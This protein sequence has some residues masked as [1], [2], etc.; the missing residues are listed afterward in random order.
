MLDFQVFALT[1]RHRSWYLLTASRKARQPSCPRP[2]GNRHEHI[3][4]DVASKEV[5]SGSPQRQQGTFFWQPAAP[6]RK[7]FLA[8]RS[9]SKGVLR[10]PRLR[11]DTPRPPGSASPSAPRPQGRRSDPGSGSPG[12]IRQ[13]E[14]C[15]EQV[16]L[17]VVANQQ[18]L[19]HRSSADR[20]TG[21]LVLGNSP[22]RPPQRII[23]LS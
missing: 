21:I 16:P 19:R 12:K 23:A 20:D 4:N 22:C 8:A 10:V 17:V 15:V 7:F 18:F 13:P 11:R 2:P 6:A 14:N 1:R 9:A 5:F 3:R